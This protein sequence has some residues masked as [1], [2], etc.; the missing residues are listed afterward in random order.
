MRDRP[1]Q[2]VLNRHAPEPFPPKP[3]TP[4][5][6]DT[7]YQISHHERPSQWATWWAAGGSEEAASWRAFQRP[8]ASISESPGREE[9]AFAQA[10]TGQAT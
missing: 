3:P 4:E 7:S 5:S 9:K 2:F 1:V 6:L 8:Q 10:G